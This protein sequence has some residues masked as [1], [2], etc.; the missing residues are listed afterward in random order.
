MILT[1]LIAIKPAQSITRHNLILA[2]IDRPDVDRVAREVSVAAEL[3]RVGKD[4]VVVAAVVEEVGV[5]AHFV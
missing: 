1:T 3:D 2:H 4:V 5:R